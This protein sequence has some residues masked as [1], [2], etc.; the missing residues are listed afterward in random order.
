MTRDA[1]VKRHGEL[2]DLWKEARQLITS[3][4][5]YSDQQ[6]LDTIIVTAEAEGEQI[7]Q[8]IDAH[9]CWRR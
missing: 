3:G 7:A 6:K 2:V 1:L 9:R 5:S 8:A 4:V